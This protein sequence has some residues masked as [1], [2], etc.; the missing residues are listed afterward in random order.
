MNHTVRSTGKVVLLEAAKLGHFNC[1]KALA[2]AGA[3]VNKQ[4]SEQRT[5]LICAT[6][7]RSTKPCLKVL[8]RKGADVNKQ[9]GSKVTLLIIAAFNGYREHVKLLIQGGAAVNRRNTDGHTAL[10]YAAESGNVCWY[11]QELM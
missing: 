6:F 4:D 11:T 2:E 1:V 8:V 3:N 5:A 10:S 9:N 7:R